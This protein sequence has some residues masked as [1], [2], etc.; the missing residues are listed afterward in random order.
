MKEAIE[1]IKKYQ[2]KRKESTLIDMMAP[3]LD[4]IMAAVK[5]KDLIQFKSSYTSLTNACNTCHR[6]TQFE[7]NIVKIPDSQP[8]SNQEFKIISNR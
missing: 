5:H 3:S 8:F 7:F 2:Q 4:S 1:N 6:D